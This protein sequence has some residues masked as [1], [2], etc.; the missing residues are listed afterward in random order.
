MFP[1]G[2]GILAKSFQCKLQASRVGVAGQA[3]FVIGELPEVF[4]AQR[5]YNR[6]SILNDLDLVA[7]EAGFD[8]AATYGKKQEP[9]VSKVHKNGCLIP[10]FDV[11]IVF[12]LS[13][14]SHS[15]GKYLVDKLI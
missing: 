12:R 5:G 3:F 10:E 7:P 9:V 8:T 13:C 11:S 14:L 15:F 2:Q 1:R 4:P 6:Q